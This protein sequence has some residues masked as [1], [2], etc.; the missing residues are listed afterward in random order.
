MPGQVGTQRCGYLQVVFGYVLGYLIIA[1]NSSPCYYRLHCSPAFT[2][3]SE[4]GSDGTG[5]DR[6]GFFLLS[7]VLGSRGPALSR[8]RSLP[9]LCLRPA[10]RS[11]LGFGHG[12]PCPDPR[13]PGA[14]ASRRWSG[15]IPCRAHFL[16]PGGAV[17][18]SRGACAGGWVRRAWWT[19]SPA[20]R[21]RRCFSGTGG[22]HYFGN[23]SPERRRDCRGDDRTRPNNMQKTLS[24][25]TLGESQRNLYSFWV[26]L[27]L[28]NAC[29]FALGVLL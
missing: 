8:S 23:N 28:V 10:E 14:A 3:T 26:I 27:V 1:P 2:A 22:S 21:C 25:R 7:R 13:P 29:F 20:V 6:R 5:A 12:H 19:A 18:R 11:L 9:G 16:V 4:R 17:G 15:P 24:C